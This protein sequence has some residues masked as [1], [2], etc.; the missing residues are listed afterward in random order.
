[1]FIFAGISGIP[2]KESNPNHITFKQYLCSETFF[3]GK[4]KLA[5]LRRDGK[6]KDKPQS[7]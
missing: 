4:M 2:G 6:S 7:N 3:L 5:Y 1:L